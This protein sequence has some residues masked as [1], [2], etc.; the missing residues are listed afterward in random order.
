MSTAAAQEHFPRQIRYIIGNEGCERFSFYGMRSILEVYMIGSLAMSEGDATAWQHLFIAAVYFTPLFGG[1]LADRFL[2][3]YKTIFYLSFGYVAGH[4]VLALWES[5]WGLFTG[6]CL[7]ALGAGGIKPCVSAFVG[8]Q[9]TGKQQHLLEKVYGWFYWII[10]LGSL[11]ST[12]AIPLLLHYSGSR[13]AFAVPGVLMAIAL[14]V[15][16]LGTRHYVKVP[17]T[18]PNPNS[19]AKVVIHA[20]RHR[21]ENSGAHWLDAAAGR[22]NEEAVEGAKAVFRITGVFAV[23]TVFWALFDQYSSS[24][25]VQAGKLD[26]SVLGVSVEASNVSTLNSVFVLAIIPLMNRYVYPWFE[27]RY[28][29]TPLRRMTVGMFIAPLAFVCAALLQVALEHGGQPNVMWQAPQYFFLSLSEVLV[30][31]TAL[32]FAYT[33]APPSLKS[34][35]MSIWFL[36]I[37][38]GNLLT[39][40]V[41]KAALFTG[42]AYFMFFA[43][44]ML[45]AAGFFAVIAAGYKPRDWMAAE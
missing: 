14:L 40:T 13:V 7:I 34:T 19:F 31:V 16:W 4:G 10:N 20:L 24:W 9:F 33:Q 8:D 25:T 22:F 42:A 36:T 27:Q 45:V 29:V 11:A 23:I 6:L 30:S 35:I 12:I 44:L 43:V 15:Y 28:R 41:A 37:S 17:P 39:A 2:G 5:K 3:R 21:G 38:F 26:L 32:E 1:Y 18:G